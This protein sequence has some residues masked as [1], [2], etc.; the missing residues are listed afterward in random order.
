VSFFSE[1]RAA[2]LRELFFETAQ[3]LLQVLNEQG[4]E[5]EK[6]PADAEVVRN[7]RRTVHTLKGDSAACGFRELSELAHEL[8]DVLTPEM[9]AQAGTALAE[10]VLSAADMFDA[11]AAAYKGK[12]QPPNG[13]PLRAMIA[14]LVQKPAPGPGSRFHPAFAWTEYERL[15]MQ[16][17][18]DS[19]AQIFNIAVILDPACQMPAAGM[20]LVLTVLEAAG[21][22]LARRPE[23]LQSEANAECLEVALASPHPAEWLERK[24]RIPAIVERVLVRSWTPAGD[25]AHVAS[26]DLA[27]EDLLEIAAEPP[28]VDPT[29]AGYEPDDSILAINERGLS[30]VDLQPAPVSETTLRVDAERIDA[31]MNLVGELIIGKSMLHQAVIEFGRRFPKDP[32]HSRFSDA[33]SHQAQILN[34]LQRSVMKIRMVPV[35]QLFRRFPRIIRDTAKRCGKEVEMRVSGQETDLDKSILDALAEPLTHL[36]RNAVDHGIEDPQGREAAGKPRRGTIQLNAYHQANHVVLEVKDDGAGIDTTKLV[37]KAVERGVISAEETARL[38]EQQK[39]ELIFE[40]GFST[41][42]E[43]TE[44]SG[45]GVGMDIVRTVL[46]RLKG[47]VSIDSRPGHGTTFRL[48]LPL[49]LAIIKALL[50]RVG[51]QL[52]AIPLGAVAEITRAGQDEVHLVEHREVLRLREQ[53]VTLVRLDRMLEAGAQTER[54][55]FFVVVVALGDRR[56][57]LIVDQLV[58]E[59]ELV[60]KALDDHLVATELVSGASILGDGT[61]VLIL[62]LTAVVEKLGRTGISPPGASRSADSRSVEASA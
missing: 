44:V 24:C 54:M 46:T 30:A 53:L 23:E 42:E 58:G 26:D 62:N 47:E 50:F 10:V 13:D 48:T 22:V 41:A 20:Q 59:D 61:V 29:M 7:L 4:L 57:G 39:L 8:E 25:L 3:E 56:F 45:R 49:T 2:E 19:G 27:R 21:T 40:P 18:S 43:I 36:V 5:L 31:V 11:L 9:A 12:M 51:A 55:R 32:L 14:R 17:E 28:H 33:M 16:K 1:E 38:S 37:A 52:Y 60:I 34:S 6:H 35:E 15:T